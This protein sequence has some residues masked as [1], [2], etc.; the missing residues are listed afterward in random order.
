MSGTATAAEEKSCFEGL[1]SKAPTENGFLLGAK[2]VSFLSASHLPTERLRTIWS[3]CD[4][5]APWY[6]RA[7]A[8]ARSRECAHVSLFAEMPRHAV[9]HTNYKNVRSIC[10]KLLPPPPFSPGPRTGENFRRKNFST[11]ASWLPLHNLD[12]GAALCLRV[13]GFF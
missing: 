9:Q 8:A 1:W 6:V 10:N 11:R 2:A 3:L 7:C 4:K 5:T 13:F 12:V